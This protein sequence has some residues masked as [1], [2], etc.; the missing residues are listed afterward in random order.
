MII[1]QIVRKNASMLF[2]DAF[3]LNDNQSNQ[4][5]TDENMQR[6][7]SLLE[8]KKK[9]KTV[10]NSILFNFYFAGFIGFANGQKC[11]S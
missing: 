8:V 11:W 4:R 7:F 2:F 6:Q 3:P 5:E 1:V 9:K 10:K